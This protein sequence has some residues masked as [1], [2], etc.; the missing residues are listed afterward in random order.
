L[1]YEIESYASTTGALIAWVQIPSLTPSTDNTIYMYYGNASAP[2]VPATTAQNVW[3][4]GYAGVWHLKETGTGAAGDYK[5]STSYGSNSTNTSA[6]PTVATGK[7]DGAQTFDGGSSYVNVSDNVL[8]AFGTG[9]FAT[10]YWQKF[11]N[12]GSPNYQVPLDGGYGSNAGVLIETDN[13]S[14]LI[15]VYLGTTLA[16]T[17]NWN[18]IVDTWYHVVVTRTGNQLSVFVNGSQLGSPLTNSTSIAHYSYLIGKYSG[19][20]FVNGILDEARVSNTARTASWIATEYANQSAPTTFESI[21]GEETQAVTTFNSTWYSSAWGYRKPIVI[22]RRKIN[23][24]TGTTTPLANFPV[25][26]SI[27]DTDLKNYAST[28]GADILFTSSDGK[29]KLNHEI[30]SY[31]SATGQL[32]AWVSVPSLT[33]T[34]DTVLYLYFGNATA[35]SQ[36]NATATWD[37]SYKGV[38]HLPNGSSL[39]VTDSTGLNTTTNH[40]AGATPGKVDGAASFNGSTQYV[41]LGSSLVSTGNLTVD[42]WVNATDP[43]TWKVFTY[44]KSASSDDYMLIGIS[45]IGKLA[46]I[47]KTYSLDNREVTAGTMPSG[48]THIAVTKGVLNGAGLITAVYVNGTSV[49]IT[50]EDPSIGAGTAANILGGSWNPGSLAIPLAGSMDE[51]RVSNIQRSA[52]WIKTEYLNQSAPQTFYAKG[53][54]Q[55]Q[56]H[57]AQQS[58]EQIANRSWYNKAWSSRMPITIS[59]NMV[60]SSTTA[61]L[62]NFP[63]LVSVTNANLKSIS[64]GGGVASTSGADILFTDSD[65]GVKLPHEIE[66]YDPVNGILIAWVKAPTISTTVDKV[67]YIYYGNSTTNLPS[68]QNATAVW[69]NGYAGVWHMKETGTGAVGDYKDSTANANNSTNT[70]QQPVA[71]STGQIGGAQT[72]GAANHHYLTIGNPSSLQITNTLTLSGWVYP[73]NDPSSLNGGW[74]LGKTDGATYDYAIY[75]G[76]SA[77]HFY[78]QFLGGG[79]TINKTGMTLN[80]NAWN[81]VNV[82]VANGSATEFYINNSYATGSAVTLTNDNKTLAFGTRGS[83]DTGVFVGNLDEIRVSPVTRSADW[84]TTEYLNQSAPGSYV[85]LGAQQT[86]GTAVA[87][88]N[89]YNASWTNRRTITIDK[90]KIS[91]INKTDLVNFPILFSTTDNEFKMPSGKVK[92]NH[93]YDFVFTDSDGKTIL[94]SEIETYASSTGQLIAWVK[95]PNL[96]PSADKTIYLYYGNASASAPSSAFTQA[97]WDSGYKSIWHLPNG[98]TLNALDSTSNGNTGGTGGWADNLP[99]ATAGKIDGGASFVTSPVTGI[100]GANIVNASTATLGL[101]IYTSAYAAN[102]GIAGFGRSGNYDKDFYINSSGYVSWYVYNPLRTITSSAILPLNQWNYLSAT[103]GPAGT[104][105]YQNGIQVAYDSNTTS[106]TGYGSPNVR[107]G[108]GDLGVNLYAFKA[109]EFRVSNTQRTP[110]WIKTEYLNQLSPSKFYALSASNQAQTRPSSVP[111]LKNRG[112]VIM[113]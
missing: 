45:T 56:N 44:F 49:A 1:N 86:S 34:S 111:L 95:I 19:G 21:A 106:Q 105:L 72:F 11:T 51:V 63:V 31:N 91:Q 70:T 32:I 64:N 59:H 67:I 6:Q 79:A 93:G 26:V 78:P 52:D 102:G 9:D 48:L 46:A 73:T 60:G 8:Y 88:T 58:N 68:Q 35:T 16:G 85:T 43:T 113:H 7:I 74:F 4:N 80:R 20:E 66:S 104:F 47:G 37:S 101:W 110:D 98:T 109:D 5:D 57:T 12:V 40:S 83:T 92:E 25:L 77:G 24:A 18:F 107:L 62:S 14:K 87:T 41:D 84:I 81:Y 55:T 100:L 23:T 99:S 94:N 29:T 54:L 61:T 22:D 13:A 112:G 2:A 69:S 39:S 33:N 42:F 71:T 103:V 15:R 82:V 50:A 3:S 65:G 10:S 17:W 97:T 90:S 96:S 108:G 75:I 76:S 89:W 36:Q 28:T 30:E 38:W 27:T 53:A